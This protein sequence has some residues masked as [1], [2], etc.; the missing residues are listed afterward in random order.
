MLSSSQTMSAPLSGT[1]LLLLILRHMKPGSN[2]C[3]WR[4]NCIVL[5]VTTGSTVA[6]GLTAC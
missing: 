2:F 5:P 6:N 4:I 1:L 3:V